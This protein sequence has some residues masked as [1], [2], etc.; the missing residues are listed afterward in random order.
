M[1]NILSRQLRAISFGS[2]T[3]RPLSR[4]F[5]FPA[6]RSEPV[7][8]IKRYKSR[9]A[10]NNETAVNQD[11]VEECRHWLSQ[12]DAKT[13]PRSLGKLSYSRSSGPGGQNVNKVSSKA[14][15]R[16]SVKDLLKDLPLLMHE[17]LYACRYY[18]KASESL[19]IQADDSRKQADNA[20]LCWQRL[21]QLLKEVASIAVPATRRHGI[22]CRFRGSKIGEQTNKGTTTASH[23][24][25]GPAQKPVMVVECRCPTF[26]VGQILPRTILC[27]G[28]SEGLGR[29]SGERQR[30]DNEVRLKQKKVHS[31]KKASRRSGRGGD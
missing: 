26:V 23:D 1:L 2:I 27:I 25:I 18:A 19:V 10:R 11:D 28:P 3:T 24:Y 6:Q 13:F 17:P 12:F 14:T 4:T 21:Y 9:V 8:I 5:F 16:V 30:R 31:N 7:W 22:L 15:L 29:A 20:E